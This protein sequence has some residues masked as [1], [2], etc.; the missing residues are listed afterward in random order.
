MIP[1]RVL[2]LF[3]FL[4]LVASVPVVESQQRPHSQRQVHFIAEEAGV[5]QPE[6]VYDE[7]WWSQ[8]DSEEQEG[9][10]NG[11]AD[12][13]VWVAHKKWVSHSVAWA[14]PKITEYYRT[15][16]ATGTLPVI[17]VWHTV[18]SDAPPDINSPAAE[19][20]TNPHGYY[21]GQ[22]WREG[23]MSEHV[24][25]LEGYLECLRT[26]LVPPTTQTYSRSITYYVDKIDKYI[27]EKAHPHS[28]HEAIADILARFRDR[29][30]GSRRSNK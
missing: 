3:G 14:R 7:K 10:L 19:K 11:A 12:C 1:C 15:H 8:K 29:P 4:A 25:F 20:W 30:K 2:A 26:Q 27:D 18:L 21:D 28:D 9:F 22:Y 6:R 24:A 17:E 16:E 13:L 5:K 23:S